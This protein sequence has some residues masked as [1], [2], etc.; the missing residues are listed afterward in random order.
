MTSPVHAATQPALRRVIG[1]RG[2]AAAI[3]NITVG[4]AI[5]VL[6]A[7][8]AGSL[9]AAARSE[10]HTSELQSRFD[11]VCRLLLEKKN[12]G[13][14]PS[15]P[16]ASLPYTHPQIRPAESSSVRAH[17]RPALPA[18]HRPGEEQGARQHRAPPHLVGL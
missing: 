8:V 6:P 9:G 3:F 16:L 18:A 7:H 4:A 10:E 15:V 12:G 11:L 14:P 5:F 1:V 17:P 13:V 2:L